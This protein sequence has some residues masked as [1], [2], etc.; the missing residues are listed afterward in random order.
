M[1]AGAYGEY[2]KTWIE[3]RW[4]LFYTWDGQLR[5]LRF[6]WLCNLLVFSWWFLSFLRLF[7]IYYLHC[8]L[9]RESAAAFLCCIVIGSES[10]VSTRL[11]LLYWRFF[12]LF[13]Y[14][15]CHESLHLFNILQLAFS[16]ILIY[17]FVI[18]IIG[19]KRFEIIIFRITIFFARGHFRLE[20]ELFGVNFSKEEVIHVKV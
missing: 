18:V 11:L 3:S 20:L 12:L 1:L 7:T 4:W 6:L 2:W 8:L 14:D 16:V 17:Y 10:F 19:I 9:S 15:V 5:I 13:I